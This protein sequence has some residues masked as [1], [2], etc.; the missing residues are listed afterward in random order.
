MLKANLLRGVIP[1]STETYFCLKMAA[2]HGELYD[3]LNIFYVV[4]SPSRTSTR[5]NTM[6]KTCCTVLAAVFSSSRSIR[7]RDAILIIRKWCLR[8]RKSNG[9][10]Y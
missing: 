8:M 7:A 2:K 4:D 9:K 6:L 10:I 3:L 5:S 1:G